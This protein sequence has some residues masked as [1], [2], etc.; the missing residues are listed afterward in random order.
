MAF[1]LA[2]ARTF[3]GSAD[4]PARPTDVVAQDSTTLIFE[5]TKQQAVV[6]GADVIAFASGVEADVREAI[7]DSALLAQL[8]ANQKDPDQ[9]NVLGWFKNYFT[10]LQTIG[11]TVQENGFVK[12]SESTAGFETH[13]SLLEFAAVALGP[14]VGALAVVTA[15]INALKNVGSNAGWITIFN[16]ETQHAEAGRFQISIVE[17]DKAGGVLVTM[18]AFT[19]EA[20]KTVTQVLFFKLT[21]T[22]ATFMKNEAKAS[23]NMA[24][25]RDLREPIRKK[26]R[27][28]QGNFLAG[29]LN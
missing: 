1:D 20:K 14:A 4:L 13:E 16:R 29:L 26:V 22:G 9:K 19:I 2:L 5:T 8:V 10:V 27:D 23:I 21:E 11:W 18:L 3:V 15:T 6:V 12:F 24:A 17:P 25:L 28:F 7:S